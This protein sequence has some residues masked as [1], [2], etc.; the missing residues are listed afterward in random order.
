MK[1]KLALLALCTLAFIACNNDDECS[2]SDWIGTYNKTSEDC[3]ENVSLDDVLVIEAGG[4]AN[5]IILA[6]D[7]VMINDCATQNAPFGI[8]ISLSGNIL[9]VEGLGCTGEYSK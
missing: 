2:Q 5:E 6:G 4:N 7:T 9:S 8:E 1:I 3:P